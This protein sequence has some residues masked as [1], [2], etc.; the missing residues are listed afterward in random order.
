MLPAVKVSLQI[1]SS[2]AQ[3]QILF[4]TNLGEDIMEGQSTTL[5]DYL[6]CCNPLNCRASCLEHWACMRS[7]THHENTVRGVGTKC[8]TAVQ[9]GLLTGGGR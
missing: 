4:S 2:Q 7:S 9:P 1:L 6:H 3:Q 8:S 5:L